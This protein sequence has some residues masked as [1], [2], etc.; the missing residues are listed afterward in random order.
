VDIRRYMYM[1]L[2]I[3][4]DIVVLECWLCSR[5][6]LLVCWGGRRGWFV[7]VALAAVTLLL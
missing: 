4:W 3:V 7:T 6:W 1:I 5:L 2:I